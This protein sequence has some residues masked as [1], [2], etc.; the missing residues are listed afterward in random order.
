MTR[1][2]TVWFVENDDEERPRELSRVSDSRMT[3]ATTA[4]PCARKGAI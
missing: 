4:G 2:A 3:G 1:Y